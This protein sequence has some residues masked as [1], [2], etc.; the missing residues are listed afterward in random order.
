MWIE[1]QKKGLVVDEFIKQ[2][3]LL[4]VLKEAEKIYDIGGDTALKEFLADKDFGT[5]EQG[6]YFPEKILG[7]RFS[8]EYEAEWNQSLDFLTKSP[9]EKRLSGIEDNLR[10]FHTLMSKAPFLQRIHS[11]LRTLNN[12]EYMTKPL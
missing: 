1:A 2:K 9:L 7:G 5:I 4:P 11:Y 10:T 8:S 12:L 6:S 3:E